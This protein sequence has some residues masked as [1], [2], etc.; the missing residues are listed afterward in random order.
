LTGPRA[1]GISQGRERGNMVRR[2]FGFI[3][4]LI[5]V[6]M[7]APFGQPSWA[8]APRKDAS[9]A[10]STL[11]LGPV[12]TLLDQIEQTLKSGALTDQTLTELR[13]RLAP[14]REGIR[15]KLGVL[16]PQ[17]AEV[18]Q[19][20][21][22]LGTP[23]GQS[24]EAQQL[25]TE[26][27]HLTQTRTEIDATLKQTRLL[28]S[29]ADAIIDKI[30]EQR[31]SLFAR[32]LFAHTVGVADLKFWNEAA[33]AASTEFT[34]LDQELRSAFD[35][36]RGHGGWSGA[37]TAA[38]VT[39]A[40]AIAVW[41]VARW[42]RRR[43]G[44]VDLRS[45]FSRAVAA[46]AALLRHA[47]A[48]PVA[49]LV[50]IR[51]FDS[52]AL[53]APSL[54]ALGDGLLVAVAVASFGRAV[55]I[56]VLAP[57][58]YRRRLFAVTTPSAT[59]LARHFI[60]AVRGLGAAIFINLLLKA[61]SAPVTLTVATSALLSL[62]IGCILL[63]LLIRLQPAAGR[64]ETEF[65]DFSR[66]VHMPWLRALGWIVLVVTAAALLTGYIGFAS[67]L[68]S[69]FLVLF[70]TLGALYVVTVFID[71][72]FADV[73]SGDAP[74]GRKLAAAFGLSPRAVDLFG[75]LISGILKLV[76]A[77]AAIF[78]A[79]GPWGVFAADFFDMIQDAMFGVRIGE[80]TISLGTVAG[81]LAILTLG[82]IATRLLQRWLDTR[83]LPLT[84]LDIG[85]QNSISSIVGY[86]GMIAVLLFVLAELGIDL[87]KIALIAGALSVG[88]GF[89]LQSIV[90]NF[91]SGLILLAE[92]PIRVG[93]WVVVKSDEGF[94][95]RISVRATEIETFE[96]ASV[97]IPNSEFIT[98]AVKNWTHGNTM[99][100]I[101][102]KVGVGYDSD[103]DQVRKILLECATSNASVMSQPEPRVFLIAFGDKA[104]EFELRC[105]VA[106]VQDSLAVKST[107]QL[108]V[109]RAF[110]QAGI[111]I[112]TAPAENKL[113]RIP[114]VRD[115]ARQVPPRG[116]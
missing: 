16:D 48:M 80:I 66:N 14:V 68:L 106:N 63:D 36:A 54:A 101:T 19:R 47:V 109:L 111:G 60:W 33:S 91:V 32:A 97:I 21:G 25:A 52:N 82:I 41:L 17:L 6:L 85:L 24:G 23:Q 11:D 110:R 15:A 98:G 90:S 40:F 79:I 43:L 30:N 22:A 96:R 18:D 77:L 39:A 53:I 57:R 84:R 28:S 26:R 83:L 38:L 78:P 20:L 95:R 94:V 61:T 46:L 2:L 93:D 44:A 55:A 87:Q 9:G 92:R 104:L 86:A 37:V 67:F 88:I 69:R 102:V 64:A 34:R 42:I 35:F 50:V 56:A 1:A 107:L 71:A 89:G 70:G 99:G 73:L 59:G 76:L 108:D 65:D 115:T 51:I 113:V 62:W 81:G 4:P 5:L 29:R 114:E 7:L 58:N 13:D 45:R 12:G 116:A 100:R 8:Q 103:P 31:R 75:T 112:P 27:Q 49:V 72:L 3:A 74:A 10:T 105:L